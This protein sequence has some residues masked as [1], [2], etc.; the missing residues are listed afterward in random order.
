MNSRTQ[1]NHIQPSVGVHIVRVCLETVSVLYYNL[2]T[3][4]NLSK[5]E[6]LTMKGIG[7]A[8][9]VDICMAM[10]LSV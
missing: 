7:N 10:L 4:F 9:S 8:E 2:L 6:S 3:C 1:H 5:S